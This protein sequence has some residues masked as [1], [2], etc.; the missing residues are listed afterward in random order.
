M[1]MLQNMTTM[2]LYL[3]IDGEVSM[4]TEQFITSLKGIQFLEHT[5][6]HGGG[7]MPGFRLQ[8]Q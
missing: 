7:V 6:E 4:T 2:V 8:T 5:T 1:T 3:M